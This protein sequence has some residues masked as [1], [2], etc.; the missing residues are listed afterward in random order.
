ME[1]GSMAGRGGHGGTRPGPRAPGGAAAGPRWPELSA[2]VRTA[3]RRPALWR[4]GAGLVL[5]AAVYMLWAA[6]T[7]GAIYLV[8]G[9]ES[10]LD[11]LGRM[12]L[13]QTPGATLLLLSTFA[14]LGLAPMAAARL[15]H[16]RRA[17]S[18]FGPRRRLVRDFLR[19]GAAVALLY[20]A[21][22]ALWSIGFDA[23]QQLETSLWLS[24]LPV[25]L[26]GVLIQT[27][28][29]ELLFRGYLLQ[30]LAARFRSP[31]AWMVLPSILFGLLHFDPGAQG[32]GAWLPVF[33]AGLFGL[34]AADL[35]ARTGS[36]GA[37][38]GFHFA[39]NVLAILVLATEGTITGL[40]LKVTPYALGAQ[41][42]PDILVLGD[43]A[44]M[45]AAWW[46]ARRLC[47]GPPRRGAGFAIAAATD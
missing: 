8:L 25:A 44:M 29:E 5:G 12:S 33:S 18:L 42:V 27:G 21:G 34:I 28:A 39:N 19:A 32:A 46:L 22:L 11:W 6:L 40:A 30:Q 7:F 35:T 3:R 31:L 24:L 45:L 13:P 2:F 10:L 1:T 20:A 36:I 14:G 26:A 47:D 17:A 43:M 9:A 37:A 23:R 38:W 4:L 16:R 41:D 15:L